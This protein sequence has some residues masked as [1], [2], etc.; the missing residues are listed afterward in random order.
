VV[1]DKFDNPDDLLGEVFSCSSF[2]SC[3]LIHVVSYLYLINAFEKCSEWQGHGTISSPLEFRILGETIDFVSSRVYVD[4]F[5][6]G[7]FCRGAVQ[8][9][10]VLLNTPD[11]V[12]S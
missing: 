11:A 8:N 7:S 9:Q 1:F 12:L 2:L 6:V 4:V 3:S 10:D 5:P